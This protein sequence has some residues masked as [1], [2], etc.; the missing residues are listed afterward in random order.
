MATLG[1]PWAD[2]DTNVGKLW[3][4]LET[5]SDQLFG[6]TQANFGWTWDRLWVDLR[7]TLGEASPPFMRWLF[8]VILNWR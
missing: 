4:D 5:T 1:R 6:S 8:G 2:V 7:A 3:I